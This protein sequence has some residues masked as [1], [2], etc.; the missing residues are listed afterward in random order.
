MTTGGS[1]G[2]AQA[3]AQTSGNPMQP[4]GAAPATALNQPNAYHPYVPYTA[5]T[6]CPAVPVA[7]TVTDP[8]PSGSTPKKGA[9]D[10]LK[11]IGTKTGKGYTNL[12]VGA[13]S[14]VDGIE[15]I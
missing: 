9:L 6:A 4:Q 8:L 12:V 2:D 7:A 5:P 15:V 14:S 1:T 13:H 11:E 10:T 3:V